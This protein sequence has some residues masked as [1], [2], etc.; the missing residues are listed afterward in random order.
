[1]LDLF[2]PSYYV[3]GDSVNSA[4]RSVDKHLWDMIFPT[5]DLSLK[6]TAISHYYEE[7]VTRFVDFNANSLFFYAYCGC[8]VRDPR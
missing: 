6:T 1:M 5:K 8:S 4:F 2:V 3:Y 7:G